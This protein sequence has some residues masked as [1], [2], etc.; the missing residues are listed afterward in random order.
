MSNKAIE[1]VDEITCYALPYGTWGV[2][3]W[4]VSS[5]TTV[6]VYA[7]PPK[8]NKWLLILKVISLLGPVIL[9]CIRC[10]HHWTFILIAVS[11]LAPDAYLL[12]RRRIHKF[13]E[14][15]DYEDD[16]FFDGDNYNNCYRL[17]LIFAAFALLICGWVGTANFVFMAGEHKQDKVSIVSAWV[18]IV[19]SII[20]FLLVICCISCLWRVLLNCL[21]K[22]LDVEE[23]VSWVMVIYYLVAS[24]VLFLH[25]VLGFYCNN[26]NG[27]SSE[28]LTQISA[29]IF[30]VG[31]NI[32]IYDL[33]QI[34][35]KFLSKRLFKN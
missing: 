9:T 27:L 29:I 12:A 32:Q 1:F 13:D 10:N 7:R 2:A 11:K 23:D 17:C 26:W 31:R 34:L 21:L 15:D 30:M 24:N 33:L 18:G 35:Y 3:C 16:T 6:Y 25:I 4:L 22:C 14:D 20:I 5:I 19:L 8:T 28:K